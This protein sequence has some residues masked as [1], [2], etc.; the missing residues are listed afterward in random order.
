MSFGADSTSFEINVI[1]DKTGTQW[2]GKFTVKSL[3]SHRDDFIRDAKRREFLGS[4][5]PQLA[6]AYTLN[7]ADVFGELSVRITLAPAFW[8]E[9]NGGL[10]LID[11]NVVREVYKKA[12][13]AERAVLD[14]VKTA[15]E[16]AKE[17]LRK[18]EAEATQTP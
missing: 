3:L 4:I 13:E 18:A 5:N 2:V 11:N 7:A 8:T 14:K 12:M 6:D 16:K 15:G 10:D 9:S 1:G 17:E